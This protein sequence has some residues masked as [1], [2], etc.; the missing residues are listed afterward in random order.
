MEMG[1]SDKEV[2]DAIRLGI[3]KRDKL[4]NEANKL[5]PHSLDLL[6]VE[7]DTMQECLAALRNLKADMDWLQNHIERHA[8]KPCTLELELR[9]A[10]AD[11]RL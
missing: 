3:I 5:K 10:I 8:V 4:S 9:R 2:Y 1:I 11:L 6:E 7:G